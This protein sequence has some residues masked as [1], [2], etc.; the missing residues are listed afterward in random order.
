MRELIPNY[1]TNTYNRMRVWLK[2]P[3]GLEMPTTGHPNMAVG[4][5]CRALGEDAQSAETGCGHYYHYFKLMIPNQWNQMIIDMHPTHKRSNSGSEETGERDYPTSSNTHNYFDLLTRFYFDFSGTISSGY[6]ASYYIDHIELYNDTNNENTNQVYGITGGY[7]PSTN[8]FAISWNRRKDENHPLTHEVRYS[9]KDIHASGWANATALSNS[10]VNA[11]GW[12]GY[13]IMYYETTDI[14]AGN[15][16]AVYFA[17]KPTNSKT[18]RQIIIPVKGDAL[19]TP[20][21]PPMA[22]S[23]LK[24][25]TLP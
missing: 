7:E 20:P 21:S 4:T 6:P 17:I 8:R 11:P 9:F 15:N 10:V 1:K 13:N 3:D 23:N 16:S 19:P 14:N 2:F 25:N 22:P 5:Y 12:G 18:F 24:V